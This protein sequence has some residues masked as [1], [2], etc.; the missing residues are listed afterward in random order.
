MNGASR[1]TVS[2]GRHVGSGSLSH[3]LVACGWQLRQQQCSLSETPDIKQLVGTGVNTGSGASAVVAHTVAS[4]SSKKRCRSHASIAGDSGARP[5]PIR[6]STDCHSWHGVE[7]SASTFIHK[8]ASP[9][10]YTGR[11]K[12]VLQYTRLLQRPQQWRRRP[13][14][15]LWQ[16]PHI[17]VPDCTHVRRCTR[18]FTLLDILV[19]VWI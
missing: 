13:R 5:W 7:R 4:L 16:W 6:T 9:S 2:L 10:S 12:N 11:G 15:A 14:W 17:Y 3:C 1:S 18:H 19:V 8:N